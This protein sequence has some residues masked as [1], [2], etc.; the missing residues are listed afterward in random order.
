M[1]ITDGLD[2]SYIR[3]QRNLTPEAGRLPEVTMDHGDFHAMWAMIV[4]TAP[5]TPEGATHDTVGEGVEYAMLTLHNRMWSWCPR[6][7]V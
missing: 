2:E 3:K 4:D 6:Q 5:D 1:R 7:R